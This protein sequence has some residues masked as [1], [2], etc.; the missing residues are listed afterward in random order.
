LEL[1]RQSVAHLPQRGGGGFSG[2]LVEYVRSA[3]RMR[4]CAG[5]ARSRISSSSSSW[6]L[7]N[8]KLNEQVETIFMM[9]RETYTFLSSR[10]VKE[11]ATLGGDVAEFVPPPVV[12]GASVA[13]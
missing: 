13:N 4:W 6:R 7:M 2:L 10:L 1:V 8:R 11:I 9:P 3:G 5:F 12:D